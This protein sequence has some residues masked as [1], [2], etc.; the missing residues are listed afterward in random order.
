MAERF[1][2]AFGSQ[3]VIGMFHATF[4][5]L[6][7]CYDLPKNSENLQPE[8]QPNGATQLCS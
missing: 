6:L 3:S 8:K 5:I 7:F 4:D 1:D 2:T